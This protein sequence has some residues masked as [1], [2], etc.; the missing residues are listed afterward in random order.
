MQET[1]SC[2]QCSNEILS[3][4]GTNCPN[5][6]HTISFY[7]GNKKKKEFSKYFALSIILPF[8]AFVG[9][10][11]TSNNLVPSIIASLV[12]VGVA[13]LLI[14]LRKKDLALTTYEKIFFWGLWGMFTALLVTLEFNIY[15]NLLK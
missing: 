3:R 14:P 2:P 10:I 1:I 15:G 13:Y 11:V 8:L 12:F 9:I 5:C 7:E 6:G 4:I